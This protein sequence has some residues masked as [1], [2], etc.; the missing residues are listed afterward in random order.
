MGTEPSWQEHTS[1]RYPTPP[2]LC[3]ALAHCHS[4]RSLGRKFVS[5]F[6]TFFVPSPG[7]VLY[8]P[9]IKL[10]QSARCAPQV[11]ATRAEVREWAIDPEFRSQLRETSRSFSSEARQLWPNRCL[12]TTV[13]RNASGRSRGAFRPSPILPRRL[14][15]YIGN[16]VARACGVETG[17]ARIAF[18]I[19]D[20]LLA[21]MRA[22]CC[23]AIGIPP[24]LIGLSSSS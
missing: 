10:S 17:A 5:S 7:S 19:S 8:T 15:V 13:A 21:R 3:M 9:S 11:N 2:A 16:C 6:S 18:A 22:F 4:P 1:Q 20:A 12:V 24:S 23:S 14:R